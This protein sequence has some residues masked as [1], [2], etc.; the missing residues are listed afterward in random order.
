MNKK[1]KI[2]ES[3]LISLIEKSVKT[4]L[5]EQEEDMIIDDLEVMDEP[6]M[7]FED[8]ME[9]EMEDEDLTGILSPEEIMDLTAEQ[10]EQLQE[11]VQYMEELNADILEFMETLMSELGDGPDEMRKLRNSRRILNQL[12]TRAG[13]EI[14][15]LKSRRLN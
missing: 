14:F 9:D 13:R 7:G 2:S 10:I 11:R 15:W 1:I 4:K 12:Q 8:E 5:S 6:L 3:D